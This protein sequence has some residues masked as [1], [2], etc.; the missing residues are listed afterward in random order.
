MGGRQGSVST[1]LEAGADVVFALVTDVARLPEWND[2]IEALESPAGELEVGDRWTVRVHLPGKRFASVSEV[3]E[4]D[5][6]ERRFVHRSKPDDDNP[7]HT[8]WTWTVEPAGPGAC[9]VQVRGR[10]AAHRLPSPRRRDAGP[11][12]AVRGRAV[13]RSPRRGGRG[14]RPCLRPRSPAWW[15]ARCRSRWPRWDRSAR[16]RSWRRRARPARWAWSAPR[17]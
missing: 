4:L 1:D 7:S 9:A 5:R 13:D 10:S 14:P 11:D 15:A 12:A 17:A 8:V 16:P 3:L 2:R 6:G